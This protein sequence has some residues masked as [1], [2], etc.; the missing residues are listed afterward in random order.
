MNWKESWSLRKEPSNLQDAY[1]DFMSL[2]GLIT[3]SIVSI[4]P[5]VTIVLVFL[6]F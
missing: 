5:L 1:M 3:A 2:C 4:S 6:Q